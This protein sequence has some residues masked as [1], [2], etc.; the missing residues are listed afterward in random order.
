MV[1]KEESCKIEVQ[2]EFTMERYAALQMLYF[3][4]IGNDASVLYH[5]LLSIGTRSQKIKNHILISKISNLSMEVME[6][7]R[8]ILEQF[9]LVKTFYN[10]AKSTYLYQVYMPK[11]GHDFLRHEVFGRLY[12]KEMGKQVYGYNKLSFSNYVEDSGTYQDITIPFVN[13]LRSDWEEEQEEVFRSS[14]PKQELRFQNDIPL[15]FNYDRFL[16]GFSNT[17]FPS[18]ARN[19]KNLRVI[20][21]LATIH[22]IHELEM[23]KLVSRSM[24][25]KTNELNVELLK[26]KARD[27]KTVYEEEREGSPYE[28][29]PVRFLQAKQH[30]VE[31]SRSDKFLIETLISDFK[32][33]P[34]VVNVLIEYVLQMKNMQFPKA[35]VEKI[36]STWVR[37]E[38][39]TYEK[40][41]SQIAQE[42]QQH[43]TSSNIVKKELPTWYQ[44][45]SKIEVSDEGFDEAALEAKIKRLRG[46]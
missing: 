13:T 32:M 40:A 30:G 24:N 10:G 36:A 44:D 6:K 18:A 16:N 27:S 35:Y 15:Q 42:K 45:Q 26:K 8:H 29:P 39:D 23:R 33:K 37:L 1:R 9:L 20:G 28:V 11:S 41:L 19:E 25:V 17:V 7:S 14:K 46:E 43:T 38:I 22:G 4:L 2:G 5:T 21:E 34:S 3:P 31:V 12:L